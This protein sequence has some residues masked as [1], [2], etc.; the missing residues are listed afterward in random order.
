MKEEFT[1]AS[2]EYRDVVYMLL[3]YKI[4][5]TGHNNYK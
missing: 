5:R 2:Q 1:T 4:D 3:G